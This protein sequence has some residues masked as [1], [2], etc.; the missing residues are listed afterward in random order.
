M[1]KEIKA[2]NVNHTCDIVSLPPHKKPIGS[3]WVY[4]VKLKADGHLNVVRLDWLQKGS[5]K[6]TE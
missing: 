1:S 2:L 6:N 3:K 4:K 5:T